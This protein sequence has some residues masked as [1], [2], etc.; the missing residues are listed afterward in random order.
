MKIL[1]VGDDVLCR[2]QIVAAVNFDCKRRTGR[3]TADD[4]T[5]DAL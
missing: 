2:Y 5:N 3:P 1:D 4:D